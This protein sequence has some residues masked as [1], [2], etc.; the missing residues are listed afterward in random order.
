MTEKSTFPCTSMRTIPF[1]RNSGISVQ[2][3]RVVS[4]TQY[5]HSRGPLSILIFVLTAIFNRVSALGFNPGS[6]PLLIHYGD[7]R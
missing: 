4:P 5:F 6:W 2:R 3:G 1:K 7:T